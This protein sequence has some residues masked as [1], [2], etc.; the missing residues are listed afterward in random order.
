M[1]DQQEAVD[2]LG[3]TEE[4]IANVRENATKVRSEPN[5]HRNSTDGRYHA[6]N[7]R[8]QSNCVG[9]CLD[10]QID[11]NSFIRII[12]HYVNGLN[13][14]ELGFQ[15]ASRSETA[16]Q[17]PYHPGCLLKLYLYGY[18]NQIHTSRRLARECQINLEVMWL[19][20]EQQPGFRTIAGF[21]SQN[22][23]AL[24]NTLEHF[25]MLCDQMGLISGQR[26]SIDGSHFRGNVSAGSFSTKRS[27]EKKKAAIREQIKQWQEQLDINDAA[28]QES[29]SPEEPVTEE[30]IKEE[31]ARLEQQLSDTEQGLKDLS[32]S[33]TNQRS[34]TDPDA[35]LLRKRGKSC[36][37]YNVQIATDHKHYLIVGNLV[38]TDT[39]DM[40]QLLPVALLVKQ[41]FGLKKLEVVADKGYYSTEGLK[42][43][44]ENQ[45]IPFVAI[46]DTPAPKQAKQRY[47]RGEFVYDEQLN[48]YRCPA[49]QLLKPSGKPRKF[50]QRFRNK[51][52][53]GH[54]DKQSQCLAQKSKY[55]EIYRSTEKELLEA[56]Q[57]RMKDNP[58]IYAERAAAVEHPFGTLKRRAGWTHF[59]VRTHKKVTGEFSLMVLSYNLTRVFS[60]LG[61]EKFMQHMKQLMGK[62][63]S[64]FGLFI[65]DADKASTIFIQA[66]KNTGIEWPKRI[67]EQIAELREPHEQV[68]R[69]SC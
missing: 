65:I 20:H 52:A 15:H 12:D 22:A 19:M 21:R 6:R 53:C 43:C 31:I 7:N 46:P 69:L 13:L 41:R 62:S 2:L 33:G 45:I 29:Q 58:Q 68:R 37:G 51:T 36:Q 55:R 40:H 60:I 50:L 25:L 23:E 8:Y 16:G 27:L 56:H 66:F 14:S 26:T 42:R 59:L 24:T 34:R 54:C 63:C 49:D 10:D 44:L 28:T 11:K 5:Q 30:K 48:A 38:G 64:G 47:A 32:D 57:E 61:F 18:R 39:Q 1:N 9:L 35:R 3:F 67:K 4:D 17:P